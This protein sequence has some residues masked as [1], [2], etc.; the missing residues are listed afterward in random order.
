MR[1]LQLIIF[2]TILSSSLLGQTNCNH[3]HSK[4]QLNNKALNN[5]SD[6]IDVLNYIINLDMTD[7]AGHIIKGNCEVSF[8]P[9]INGI[10]NIAL[11][12]LELNVDSITLQGAL[13]TYTYNDTLL[14]ITLP[15]S[16]NTSD[17]S[18]IVV[19]YNGIPQQD[20]SGW[21]GFY[22]QSGYTF[23]LGVGFSA[24]PHNYGRVWFPC[25]DN[26]VERSSYE[27]N[28]ITAQGMKAHCNGS[29]VNETIINADTISRNWVLNEEIPTYLACVA[30]AA[31]E[32][33][34]IN[35]AGINGSVP[36]ELVAKASDT[37][38]M[39]NSFTHL[40]DA[41]DIYED[42]YGP[43]RWNKVGFSLVPF[44]SGAMEHATNIAYPL[45][46]AN[47][48][49]GSET[50]MA[51]EFAHHWW[52]NL[53]TC[54]TAED[55]WINE[56]MAS[57]SEH[58]FLE[59]VYDH[60]AYIN[61]VINNHAAILQF[62]HV[63]EG[64]YLPISGVPHEYTYGDHTYKKGASVAH[65]MRAYMGD[66]LFFYGLR[67][68][69][70]N[71]QFKDISASQ[72]RD[73]LIASTGVD[74]NNF[75]NDWVFS[76]GYSHFSIDSSEVVQN[77][78]NFDV[79]VHVKQKL[80]GAT[81]FHVNTPV[82]VTFFDATWGKIDTV[83]IVSGQYTTVTVTIPFTP[84]LTIVNNNNKLNQARTEDQLVITG[85]GTKTLNLS[86]FV[87][88]TSSI[89]DSA[90]MQIEHHWVAPDSI[91]NNPYNY[92]ISKSRYWSVK[93]I[94]PST[95][96]ATAKLVYDGKASAGYLDAGLVSQTEDSLILLYREDA[97]SDWIEYPYYTKNML[98]TTPAYGWINIS[99]LLL[100]EYTFA[101]GITPTSINEELDLQNNIIIYPNPTDSFFWIEGKSYNKDTRV[102]VFDLAGKL[103]Y[104]IKFNKKQKIN[105]SKWRAG[106]YIISL[107]E[108]EEQ[109]YSDVII[110]K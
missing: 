19:Y 103:I 4:P 12:L 29:L 51:H 89:V 23:N 21:G 96:T 61:E 84:V 63:N 9:K 59:K 55:M 16:L 102:K 100:G 46:A 104:S 93:G 35:H 70:N 38:N 91:K 3:K 36:I 57:Y 48:S 97:K 106:T 37:T 24:N 68:I 25:F 107:I 56:G 76:P 32:T 11:D 45:S 86:N 75:F 1:I 99:S 40:T 79:T 64:G 77:G 87:L 69:T 10:S 90:L 54:K 50:L 92:R 13:L 74:M 33:V 65:N 105:T 6:T 94:L 8:S 62:A 53:V 108:G 2:F 22:Y 17:T 88:T 72:F 60:D 15:T 110:V 101:N 66:S 73:E 95:Y 83:I 43:Y 18:S 27:F 39:K 81:N 47:G 34:D 14:N 30:V 98:G 85:T 58:L 26:F 82:E 28:I 52:G 71:Y 44:S 109:K 31:Y 5:R 78:V 41:I 49:L 7:Y 42:N 20:A 67:S 80:K